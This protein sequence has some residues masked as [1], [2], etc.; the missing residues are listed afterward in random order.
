MRDPWPASAHEPL[1]SIAVDELLTRDYASR[2]SIVFEGLRDRYGPVAPVE[3]LGL[4]TW[5]VLGYPQAL[6]VLR[7]ERGVWSKRLAHWR[8]RSEG[9]VPPDWPIRPLIET[10]NSTRQGGRRL[11]EFRAAWSA[12][13]T[14]FQDR[15]QA[16]ARQLEAEVSSYADDLISELSEGT[17]GGGRTGWAD[18]CAQYTRPLPLM[19]LGRLLGYER[20]PSD[21]V[22]MDMWRLLDGSPEAGAAAKR[23]IEA[24]ADLAAAKMARPGD[25]FPSYLV[26]ARP[27]FTVEELSLE[28]AMLV[29][30]VGDFTGSLISNTVA[31]VITGNVAARESLSDGMIRETVNRVAMASPPLANTFRFPMIDTKLGQFTISA[32]DTVLVSIAAAHADPLFAGGMSRDTMLSSRAHLAWGAGAHHCLGRQLATAITSVAVSRL[33]DRF[34]A[35]EL[36]LPADQLPWRYSPLM[37]SLRSLPVRFTLAEPPR[38]PRPGRG[39]TAAAATA[40]G[41]AAA[42]A[43][44]TATPAPA[45]RPAAETPA[46]R[47]YRRG[48]SIWR[49]PRALRRRL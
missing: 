6:E 46:Q 2:P 11:S 21:D 23:L 9:A 29:G 25:D 13:L 35:L 8:A 45:Q 39:A 12:A 16:P 49:I 20:G 48:S 17:E 33:F 5:L 30:F 41:T 10:E 40:A 47:D 26:A 19:V 24:W 31:E 22:I 37:R 4:P 3:L 7:D 34:S 28:L 43:A 32:G 42:A 27:E 38:A 44:A 1:A 36:A 14:P 15:T 18:L